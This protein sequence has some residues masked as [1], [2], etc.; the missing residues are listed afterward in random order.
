[1]DNVINL[2]EYRKRRE[3]EREAERVLTID[4]ILSID[5]D[6]TKRELREWAS[7]TKSPE[8]AAALQRMADW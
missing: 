3:A 2:N 1:M 6:T 8:L 5:S 7:E 4:E